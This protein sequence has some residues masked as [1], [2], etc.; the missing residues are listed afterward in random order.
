MDGAFS[1]QMQGMDLILGFVAPIKS[2][3]RYI[4][5]RIKIVKQKKKDLQAKTHFN[6]N[7]TSNN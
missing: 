3:K 7:S 2:P 5:K 4:I 1:I 6:I